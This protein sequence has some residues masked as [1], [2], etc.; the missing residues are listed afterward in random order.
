MTERPD[1]PTLLVRSGGDAAVPVWQDAFRA[2]LPGVAVRSWNDPAVP[3]QD[4]CYV[5]VWEP[6]AG[7][8]AAYPNLRLIF[9]TAAGVDHIV[10]DPARPPQV[11]II[12]MG[13]DEMAQ[14]VGEYACL[15]ALAI[16]RDLP[17]FVAAQREARWDRFEPP[18]TARTTSVGIMGLGGIGQVAAR[19]L[20]DIGL[21]INGWSRTRRTL[22]DIRCYAGMA[23]LTAFLGATDILVAVLPDTP[24]T[25][26]LLDAARLAELPRGAGVV[27]VGRGNLIIL[28]DLLA[29][30][31]CGQIS[32]AMLDVFPAEPLAPDDPAWRHERLVVTPHLAGFASRAA[33]A[34]WVADCIGTFEAGGTLRNVFD[35][36]R[37]Y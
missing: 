35:P 10:R 18:R 14:T 12:R 32:L 24:E 5:L 8:L 23:E 33:R 13:A 36:S 20:R 4:V 3:P 30:L 28:P 7:R 27:N 31:D 25:A 6:E 2:V 21:Q 19:M 29:A 15:A 22:Q 17:R 16:L 9:S 26:S 34:A 1:A 37:G 11:P